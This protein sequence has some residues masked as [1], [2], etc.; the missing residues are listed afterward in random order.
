MLFPG[1]FN[2]QT[3]IY[4]HSHD[5]SVRKRDCWTLWCVPVANQ[6]ERRIRRHINY[7]T[8]TLDRSLNFYE[9]M[10]SSRTSAVRSS[11][12]LPKLSCSIRTPQITSFKKGTWLLIIA[13]IAFLTRSVRIPK[14]SNK[15]SIDVEIRRDGLFSPT[16][17]ITTEL[18]S[19]DRLHF[20]K[21]PNFT[22]STRLKKTRNKKQKIEISVILWKKK[23]FWLV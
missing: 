12:F 23:I 4:R 10:L 13:Q 9:P 5:I 17:K 14:I 20:K 3:R 15:L 19:Y 7:Q 1:Q 18:D 21:N 8:R 6:I 22:C 2:L 11:K 16:N